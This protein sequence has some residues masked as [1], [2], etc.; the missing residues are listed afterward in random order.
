[1]KT[2]LSTTN[3]SYSDLYNYVAFYKKFITGIFCTRR[4]YNVQRLEEDDSKFYRSKLFYSH[5]LN[6]FIKV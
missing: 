4:R 1:M 3:Y 6:F 5:N 2:L